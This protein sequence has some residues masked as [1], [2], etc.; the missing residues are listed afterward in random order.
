M[1]VRLR[2]LKGSQPPLS[3]SSV[4]QGSPRSLTPPAMP[5]QIIAKAADAFSAG[6]LVNRR[7]RQTQNWALSPF[8]VVMGTI[9][10]ATYMRGGREV[11]GLYPMEPNFP[12]WGQFMA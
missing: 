2:A 4:T 1:C 3:P 10:P 6:D 8:A 5:P 7:V 11:L 12:R 9:F